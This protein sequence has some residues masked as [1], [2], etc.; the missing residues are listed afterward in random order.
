M[1]NVLYGMKNTHKIDLKTMINHSKAVRL[2]AKN[3][4]LVV[5]MPKKQLQNEKIAKKNAKIIIK[6]TK[7]DAVKN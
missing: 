7:C 3:S 4:L 1:A 6:Q 5:D 2:G